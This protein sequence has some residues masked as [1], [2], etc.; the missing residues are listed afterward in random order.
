MRAG[1]SQWLSLW[2]CLTNI[3]IPLHAEEPL[4]KSTFHKNSV[5]F[6]R[7]RNTPICRHKLH[8]YSYCYVLSQKPG[9]PLL[10]RTGLTVQ[11]SWDSVMQIAE[12]YNSTWA[13]SK[14]Q[15][16]KTNQES[17]T[18][19][20]SVRISKSQAMKSWFQTM[21]AMNIINFDSIPMESFMV[22]SDDFRPG[23]WDFRECWARPSRETKQKRE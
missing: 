5:I 11:N 4:W 18:P 13:A 22:I 2:E 9:F 1:V 21:K 23:V 19:G 16:R 3:N 8:Y 14:P 12:S 17:D 7:N 15:N 10:A 20:N 6:S